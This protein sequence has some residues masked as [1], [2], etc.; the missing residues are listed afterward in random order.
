MYVRRK[1]ASVKAVGVWAY[2]LLASLACCLAQRT[3]SVGFTVRKLRTPSFVVLQ[4]PARVKFQDTLTNLSGAWNEDEGVFVAPRGGAYFFTFNGIGS[5]DSDFTLAL[6]KNDEYQVTAYGGPP[7]YEW[8]GNS[9]LLVLEPGD[10]VH[11]QLQA[12][13]M[14]D[15]PGREAYTTFT[16][17]LMYEWV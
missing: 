1:I 17:F 3:S 5:K 6:M 14:Y 12:G 13:T 11:L 10:K 4:A 16:G 8:A 15:H 7:K 9:A 2:L